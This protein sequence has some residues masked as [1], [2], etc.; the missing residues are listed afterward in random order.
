MFSRTS[1]KTGNNEPAQPSSTFIKNKDEAAMTKPASETGAQESAQRSIPAYEMKRPTVRTLASGTPAQKDDRNA[2]LHVGRGLDLKGEIRSCEALV[3]EGNVEAEIESGSLTVGETG[4]VKGQA[5]VNEA[6][7]EGNFE[8][9][10]NVKGCLSIKATGKI[11]GTVNYGELKVEQGGQ[12][13]GT[14]DVGTGKPAAKQS[15]KTDDGERKA[16]NA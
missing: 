10:L 11:T 3:I 13:V 9:T 6:E 2:H 16:A 1:Q 14:L 12:V 5:N 7:I 15:S 4:I 8:G